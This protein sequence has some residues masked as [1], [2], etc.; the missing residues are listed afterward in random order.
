MISLK[1]N[2]VALM[3]LHTTIQAVE[4]LDALIENYSTDS[5][6]PAYVTF[7]Y[8]RAGDTKVQFDREI[9]VIAL[10]AQRARLTAYL[11][12]LGIIA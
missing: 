9:M 4:N 2:R 1:D 12:T 7:D 3:N 8:Y 10:T 11:E 5:Q 6:G